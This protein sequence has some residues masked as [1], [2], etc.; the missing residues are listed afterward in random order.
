METLMSVQNQTYKTWEC[1]IVDDFS[2]DNTLTVIHEK[3]SN[4]ERFIVLTNKRTKGAQGSRNTGV[5]HSK[6]DYLIFL[7]SDDLISKDCLSNRVLKFQEH[8]EFDFLVFST[9]EFKEAID[10]TNVL[11]NVC[12]KENMLERFLNLDIPWLIMAPIWRRDSFLRLGGFNEEVRSWQDWELHIRA[13]FSN[14]T[15]MYFSIV[16]NFY[17]C[18][19]KVVSVGDVAVNNSEHVRSHLKTCNALKITMKDNASYLSRLNGLIYWLGE[20]SLEHGDV[21]TAKQAIISSHEDL[22]WVKRVINIYGLLL[23][24]KLLIPHPRL[25]DFGTYRK[26][27]FQC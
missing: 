4:D 1:I 22:H 21:E 7:D 18:S 5:E 13:V 12:T 17:R 10:D 25:P 27:M 8:R 11:V 9:V 16:D 26:I 14:Y 3:L 20:R 15:F 24:K 23:L 2:T 6:G 19:N